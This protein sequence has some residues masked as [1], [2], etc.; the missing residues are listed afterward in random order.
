LAAL[1]D[2]AKGAAD[3]SCSAIDD[4]LA[5]IAASNVRIAKMERR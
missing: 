4:S 3:R 5:F 1:A 2:A